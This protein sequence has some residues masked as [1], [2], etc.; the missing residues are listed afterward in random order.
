MVSPPTGFVPIADYGVI[1]D[2]RSAALVSRAGSIDWLCLPR[3]SDPAV[4]AALLDPDRGGSFSIAPSAPFEASRRYLPGTNVLETTFTCPGGELRLTDCMPVADEPVMRR[5]LLPERELLRCVECTR[6]EVAVGVLC[7]PRPDFARGMPRAS[8]RGR[9][10]IRFE[11]PRQRLHLASEIPLRV[12]RE[13]A[14]GS[15][16]LRA[17]ERRFLSLTLGEEEPLVVPPLGDHAAERLARSA[18]WW[19]AWADR[20]T[21]EGPHRDQVV[22]SALALKLLAFT[23]S[24]AI[25]AAP[26]TSLPETVGG[27]RNWDYRY[28]WLRDASLTMRAL[29][30]LG[31]GDEAGAFL[32]WL[33]HATRQTAPRLQVVYD[34]WGRHQLIEHTLPHL[35]GHLD[36]RPVRTGNAAWKQFQLDIYGPVIHAAYEFVAAGGTIDRDQRRVLAQ[37]AGPLTALCQR[38]DQG[39]WES[40]G[41]PTLHTYSMATS[42]LGFDRL[43]RM[44]R[45][46][47][48]RLRSP[49]EVEAARHAVR[50]RIESTCVDAN[51]AYAV[52]PGSAES[53]A[54]LLVLITGGYVKPSSPRARATLAEVERQLGQWPFIYRSPARRGAEAAFGI[55][56]FWAA[57]AEAVCGL[58]D[59]AEDR[60]RALFGAA[61]DLGLYA[62]ETDPATGALIGNFPQGFSH[63][64]LINA[65]VMIRDARAKGSH[66]AA[67]EQEQGAARSIRSTPSLVKGA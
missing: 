54:S 21:Y 20:C 28:C 62:E 24:G 53:D 32:D 19:R 63:L 61:N 27:A 25:I 49:A 48:I 46:G 22:R 50:D 13:S 66:R 8:S 64:G 51:G 12:E 40:R 31:H 26:T 6:G 59:A 38:P 42:W 37:F 35:R 60:F 3:F 57:E 7:R 17:G 65:A 67:A 29:L 11:H 5:E 45:E 30:A 10:G 39:I 2:C 55:C 52:G 4:F 47:T 44:H 15:E 34:I 1:G 56:G 23:P 41:P 14:R 43:L 16:T 36:S 58:V 9:A 18:R 33:L